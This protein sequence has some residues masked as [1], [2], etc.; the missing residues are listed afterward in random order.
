MNENK[1]RNTLKLY[2]YGIFGSIACFFPFLTIYL[3][4]KGLSY[5]Q[6]GIS[7]ALWS[8]V[9]IVI[10]PLWGIIADRYSSK[11]NVL[12]IGFIGSAICIYIL[13]LAKGFFLVNVGIV[14]FFAFQC[15][16]MTTS[17]AFTYEIVEKYP[18]V[19]YGK[20]RFFGSIGY[21]MTSLLL[22]IVVKQLSVTFALICYS[23]YAILCLLIIRRIHFTGYLSRVRMNYADI[24]IQIKDKRF[25]IF[26]GF[27]VL[28]SIALGANGSYL[29]VLV[30][31]TGGT[32][33]HLGLLGFIIAMSEF[34]SFNYGERIL[35]RFGELNLL[36]VSMSFYTIRFYLDSISGNH[37]LTLG[38]QTL[39]SC[40][41]PLFLISC[42]HYII[43]HSD[44]KIRTTS[45]MIF[46][47]AGS[48][49]GLVG[50]VVGGF[51]LDNISIFNL[52]R[53]LSFIPVICIFIL[54]FIKY[55]DKK[56]IGIKAVQ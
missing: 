5:S 34:F 36:L 29:P 23:V 51:L 40:T 56:P 28:A 6:V 55:L 10:Q 4:G 17:D 37:F 14:I 9:G 45:M 30:K 52:Y 8:L 27:C 32:M 47:A 26:I 12:S 16:I 48:I 20:V 35:K 7:F 25:L 54:I 15:A 43:K 33:F 19:Q 18:G 13:I 49:G 41:Y 53:I 31:S 46:A 21:A 11:K 50:N 44:E 24:S 3:K 39:Q 1:L 38:I 2:Y 22:G 42:Y